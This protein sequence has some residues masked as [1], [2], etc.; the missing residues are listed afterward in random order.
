VSWVWRPVFLV[1]KLALLGPSLWIWEVARRA[2]RRHVVL[3]VLAVLERQWAAEQLVLQVLH[4]WRA[5]SEA[6]RLAD[7][8]FGVQLRRGAV[9]SPRATMRVLR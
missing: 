9:L 5:L 8:Q 7:R 4:E 1:Q 3:A 2:V 6:V